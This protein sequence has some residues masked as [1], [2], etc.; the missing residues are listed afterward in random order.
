MEPAAGAEGA[1]GPQCRDA[2]AD[3]LLL[4]G[5]ALE[6]AALVSGEAGLGKAPRGAVHIGVLDVGRPDRFPLALTG[7]PAGGPAGQ[8]PS[9]RAVEGLGGPPGDGEDAPVERAQLPRRQSIDRG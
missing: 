6:P 7:E 5:D 2:L 8:A 3:D 1:G 9:S 4:S